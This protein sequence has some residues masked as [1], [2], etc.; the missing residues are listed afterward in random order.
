MTVFCCVDFDL[1]L[2][3]VLRQDLV[4]STLCFGGEGLQACIAWGVPQPMFFQQFLDL[5]V[6][7]EWFLRSSK[8]CVAMA[9]ACVLFPL[10]SFQCVFKFQW[11]TNNQLK[12]MTR[13]LFCV[14]LFSLYCIVL[15]CHSIVLPIVFLY[16]N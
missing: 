7:S 16:M 8:P 9:F 4:S 5:I 10:L 12:K 11:T 6:S 1:F 13:E 15:S 3:Y 2:R 14:I